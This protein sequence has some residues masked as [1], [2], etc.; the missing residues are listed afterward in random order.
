MQYVPRREGVNQKKKKKKD[1]LLG[2]NRLGS[3]TV[4]PSSAVHLDLF[5]SHIISKSHHIQ[6]ILYIYIYV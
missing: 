1:L 4:R 2:R 3:S 6:I 5:I